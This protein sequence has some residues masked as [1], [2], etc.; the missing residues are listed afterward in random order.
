MSRRLD[1]PSAT[2][3]AS[4]VF[5]IPIEAQSRTATISGRVISTAQGE[6]IPGARVF[7]LSLR[8]MVATDSVGRFAFP[9]LKPGSYRIEAN[10]I[11][12]PPLTAVVT[13]IAGEH[14]DIE[15]RT[16]SLGQLLPTVFVEGESAPNLIRAT[17]VFERRMAVGSGRF[18]T[19]D[20]IVRRNPVRIVDMIRFLPG[21]RSDCRGFVCQLR[22]NHDPA[23]CPPAIFIDDQR[24]HI[25]VLDNTPA[26]DVEGVEIYRGPSETP[27]ELNNETAR[28]GG[29]IA[30]W[31]RRGQRHEN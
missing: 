7:L 3:L 31:T 27:P 12:M 11:G 15:F 14:K 23:N 8:K 5:A 24:S 13:V 29:A 18:I 25:S 10:L 16:D 30:L 22:L 20:E 17:T 9:D 26:T 6:P 4:L 2:V 28:C 19:R 21:V 1:L